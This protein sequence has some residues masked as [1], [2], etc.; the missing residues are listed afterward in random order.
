MNS[1]YDDIKVDS[2]L[3]PSPDFGLLY[4]VWKSWELLG[5]FYRA[6]K[7]KWVAQPCEARSFRGFCP[8]DF[9]RE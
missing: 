1:S 5:T 3:D 6:K 4:R 8:A 9:A 7:G 2:V